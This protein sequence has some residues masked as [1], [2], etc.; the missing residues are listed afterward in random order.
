MVEV[1]PSILGVRMQT[2]KL[3][4]SLAI[5]SRLEQIARTAGPVEACGVLLGRI[6][7]EIAVVEDV[8][9][10]ENVLRSR[11]RFWF[12]LREWMRA[13]L[14]GK[15]RG[16][17]YIGIFHTHPRRGLLPSL[18]DRQRM[19]ECPGEIWLILALGDEGLEMAAWRVDDWDIGISRVRVEVGREKDFKTSAKPDQ[20]EK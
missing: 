14:E 1:D 8:V 18:S 9:R 11:D 17:E 12:D 3:R 10:L 13:V 19:L 15:K 16:F 4:M 6:E 7:G 20:E 2:R 5:A